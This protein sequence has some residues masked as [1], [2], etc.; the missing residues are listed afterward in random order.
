MIGSLFLNLCIFIGAYFIANINYVLVQMSKLYFTWKFYRW[1]NRVE[2]NWSF[3][4]IT[5]RVRL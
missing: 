3:A 4:K 1:L 2:R 5:D